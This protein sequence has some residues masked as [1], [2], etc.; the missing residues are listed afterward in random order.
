MGCSGAS[1]AI[2]RTDLQRMDEHAMRYYEEI[3]KETSDIGAISQ[4]T[5]F[6]F[7]EIETIKNHIFFN[8]HLLDS[9]KLRRQKG[10]FEMNE[11]TLKEYNTERVVYLYL[12][13]GDGVPGE[14][15]YDNITKEATVLT[16][17]SKDEFGRYGHN[18]SRKL[19]EYIR[20]DYLPIHA[21]QAWN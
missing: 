13:E 4:N 6:S 10:G 19:K 9:K 17:A 3:R 15:A 11:L 12:P 7:D 16:R 1:G 20:E 18:A 21:I 5:G 2:P 14:I 8:E